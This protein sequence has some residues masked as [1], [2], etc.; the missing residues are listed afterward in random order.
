[1]SEFGSLFLDDAP[2]S[3][4]GNIL[5]E[6]GHVVR[7][8]ITEFAEAI[9]RGRGALTFAVYGAWGSGKTSFLKM[10]EDEVNKKKGDQ[11]IVFCWYQA[12]KYE[13]AGSAA[14]TLVQ[15]ILRTLG[16]EKYKEA[17]RLYQSFI[18]AMLGAVPKNWPGKGEYEGSP[19]PYEWVERL[20][21]K[22]AA[23]ADLDLWLESQLAG[24][25]PTGAVQRKMVL[26]VDD[27]DRCSPE[28]IADVM[29]TIQRLGAVRGLFILIGV[30]RER[31]WPAI[32]ARHP[33]SRGAQWVLEKYI[34]ASVDLPSLDE[35]LISGFLQRAFAEEAANDPA[36]AAIVGEAHYFMAGLRDK[37]P[38]TIK[39]CINAIWPVLRLKLGR[40]P[41][42][43][44]E[45]QQL[46]IKEQILAYQWRSFYEQYFL[47]ARRD[48]ASAEYR[49]LYGLEQLCRMLYPRK[50]EWT[51]VE[52]QRDRRAIFDLRLNRLK[53]SEF[54]TEK[55]LDVPD[56]LAYLLGEPPFWFLGHEKA[57]PYTVLETLDESARGMSFTKL[58]LQSEQ[59][60]AI[61]DTQA[62]VEAADQAYRLVSRNK[63]RFGAGVAPQLGNLGVNAEKARA[64]ELA[65]RL[66]RLALELDPNHGG[67]LQQFASYIIDNRPDLYP[68]A[69]QILSRLQTGPLA[70]HNPWRTLGLLVELKTKLGQE[71]DESLVQ[72]M[73]LAAQEK[74]VNARQLAIILNGLIKAGR[75]QE[76]LEML[77]I[78]VQR[79]PDIRS[80]YT[81]SRVAADALADRPEAENEFIAMDI[82]RQMLAAPEAMDPGDEADVLHNYATLLYKHDYDDEAGRLWYRAYGLKPLDGS[83]RRAYSM[84]LL[85]ANRPDLG[86]RVADGE[87]IDE[88]VLTPATRKLP[89]R[90]SNARLP[91]C[92]GR[93]RGD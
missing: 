14:K 27:L 36:L 74:E 82:Y 65:E 46:I 41:R 37:T 32:E 45:E 84:Y 1:M 88:E 47:P 67:V 80:C 10:V 93:D 52:E 25:G 39:R 28:F 34:Q 5:W 72:Q 21:E 49:V 22:V 86:R 79:F 91:R 24:Q 81:L 89:E 75:V 68:E 50:A 6:E 55:D 3:L 58:Y 23:L 29:D 76:S 56:E 59:A 48:Q 18:K 8:R 53:A 19:L 61:G 83:I 7:R 15:R 31:L 12:R 2:V 63:R 69:E 33:D 71:I 13:Q 4:E 35:E 77:D 92:L 30:D 54:L 43:T 26:M 44:H 20:G 64:M 51:S 57:T 87:P 85:R 9:V 11:N 90:F 70:S 17:I 66:F 40:Q 16:G 60:D 42:L 78:A 73:V 38:R 62:S